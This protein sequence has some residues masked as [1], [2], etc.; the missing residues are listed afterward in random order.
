MGDSSGPVTKIHGHGKVDVHISMPKKLYDRLFIY[1]EE[2][3]GRPS[4]SGVVETALR[5]W[6]DD[7]GYLGDA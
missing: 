5:Q 7:A 4:I 1:K 2:L 6:L 3:V